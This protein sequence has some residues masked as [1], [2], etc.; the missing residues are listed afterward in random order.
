[1]S[2]SH[3]PTGSDPDDDATLP[4]RV[5]LLGAAALAGD[6]AAHWIAAAVH[7]PERDSLVRAAQERDV[8][9]FVL[10]LGGA[11]PG[12][13]SDRSDMAA[14]SVTPVGSDWLEALEAVQ[15]NLPGVCIASGA[16]RLPV[17]F[18]QR[19]MALGVQVL[20]ESMP[21]AAALRRQ[22]RWAIG[23]FNRFSALRAQLD[24][25]KWTDRAKGLLMSARD[26]D[27]DGAF[28]LLRD[29]A[30]HAHLRLGEVARSVVQSA[31]LAEAVNLAGQQRMLSQRLVKLMAQ[32]AAGIEVKRAKALQDE[33]CA[34]V[35]ANLARLPTLVTGLLPSTPPSPA[36]VPEGVSMGTPAQLVEP[37]INA[38]HR[39]EPLLLGKPATDALAAADAAAQDLLTH[40]DALATA[41]AASGGGKPLHVVNV[42]GRQRMLSQQLAKEALLA[43]LLP[44][45]DPVVLL[46]S[47]DRFAA[48][49]AELESS[50]LSS[51]AIRAL[52]AEVGAEWLRLMRSVRVTHGREAAEGLARSSEVMLDRLELLT[53][54]YQQSLQIILG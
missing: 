38:W 52:L 51:D 50:P 22:L 31:Q 13:A 1:M 32:R 7:Q 54:H 42:C 33:S 53:V 49:L 30:M 28:R 18:Q 43:D 17:D 35:A 29:A 2:D 48:G 47:L 23:S 11:S 5:L 37:V 8:E 39:L 46:D 25:R 24:D 41:L 26:L 20:L 6:P 44:G 3:A 10:H 15:I 45:R 36:A 16:H 14:R 9:A 4:R 19:A 27:E 12:D 21:D 40:S 34:R